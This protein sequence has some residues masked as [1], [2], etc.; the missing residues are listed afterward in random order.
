MAGLETMRGKYRVLNI[1]IIITQSCTYNEAQGKT[2][3]TKHDSFI[4]KCRVNKKVPS[5]TRPSP[6]PTVVSYIYMLS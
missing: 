2:V 6:N 1:R 5:L 4:L 3:E